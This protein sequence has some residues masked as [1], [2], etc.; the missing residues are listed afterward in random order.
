[1]IYSVLILKLKPASVYLKQ[2]VIT[3]RLWCQN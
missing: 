2:I 3:K 1:M